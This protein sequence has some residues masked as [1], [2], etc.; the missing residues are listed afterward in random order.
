MSKKFKVKAVF[1]CLL[2]LVCL[3]FNVVPKAN[4]RA[5]TQNNKV[6]IN[7]TLLSLGYTDIRDKNSLQIEEYVGVE[8]DFKNIDHIIKQELINNIYGQLKNYKTQLDLVVYN[9]LLNNSIIV[10]DVKIQE[11]FIFVKITY[12]NL[13]AYYAFNGRNMPSEN[14]Q[15][16]PYDAMEKGLFYNKYYL[17]L[18]NPLSV[19]KTS[20]SILQLNK[21][22]NTGQTSVNIFKRDYYQSILN[23]VNNYSQ[24]YDLLF[25]F[26]YSVSDDRL[27]GSYA[28]KYDITG[29]NSNTLTVYEFVFNKNDIPNN[30]SL[31]FVTFNQYMWYVVAIAATIV[32]IGVLYIIVFIKHRKDKQ[33][34]QNELEISSDSLE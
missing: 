18:G 8:L 31:Y 32:V 6:Y 34:N 5:E 23:Y 12:L 10:N 14:T 11:N 22:N 24:N 15:S 26:D 27:Y 16:K 7:Y 33:L 29:I 25:V 9:K 4:L 17:Y 13:P 19:F 20:D 21:Q 3:A 28:T 30:V 1:L 2:I